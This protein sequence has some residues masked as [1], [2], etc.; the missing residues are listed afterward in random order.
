MPAEPPTQRVI[1][2]A[3]RT[4]SQILTAV[5]KRHVLDPCPRTSNHL[6]PLDRTFGIAAFGGVC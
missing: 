2:T 4:H 5:L 3:L 6:S 1:L